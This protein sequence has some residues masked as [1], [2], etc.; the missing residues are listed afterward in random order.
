MRVAGFDDGVNQNIKTH[1][2]VTLM[3]Q[4]SQKIIRHKVGRLN[5]AEELGN[6]SKA[7]QMMGPPRDTFYRYRDAVEDGG[8]RGAAGQEPPGSQP[9]KTGSTLK[10]K[11]RLSI[12][13]LKAR[14]MARSVS[15][16]SCASALCSSRLAG[17]AVSGFA[18]TWPHFKTRLKALEAKVAEE[19]M[20]LTETQVQALEKKKLDD[21]A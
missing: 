5:L 15:A 14:P 4:S 21:E 6:V 18:M 3:L 8:R 11:P 1:L 10:S 17:C 9:K 13:P 20:I 2:E 7:C 19:G 16:T 12:T